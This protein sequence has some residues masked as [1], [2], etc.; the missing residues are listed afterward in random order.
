MRKENNR[1]GK[2]GL[3]KFQSIISFDASFICLTPFFT[4]S[5]TDKLEKETLFDL[6]RWSSYFN[7]VT[8]YI[9]QY[10]FCW[11]KER[12]WANAELCTEHE[13]Q[14]WKLKVKINKLLVES[15]PS[16]SSVWIFNLYVYV[17]LRL[18]K[19]RNPPTDFSKLNYSDRRMSCID[20]K[21][22]KFKNW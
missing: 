17:R 11:R 2:W 1:R 21:I 5:R 20:K 8:V 12:L 4:S 15:F 18:R 10:N 7:H 6:N 13:I 14:N 3:K 9:S 22:Q 19:S 16:V